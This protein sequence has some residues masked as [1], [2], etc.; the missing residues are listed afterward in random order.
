[1]SRF[2]R[3]WWSRR[4]H[5]FRDVDMFWHVDVVKS[6]NKTCTCCCHGLWYVDQ[7]TSI[8][9]SCFDDFWIMLF[10]VVTSWFRVL[11]ILIILWKTCISWYIV[12]CNR[13]HIVSFF[14]LVLF[15]ILVKGDFAIW[16]PYGWFETMLFFCVFCFVTFCMWC[17]AF[18]VY[19][20]LRY[21][22][23]LWSFWWYW[24]YSVCACLWCCGWWWYTWSYHDHVLGWWY[25]DT[26]IVQNL[27]Y[28]VCHKNR[29][30]ARA[31]NII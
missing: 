5:G 4:F 18:R 8:L 26:F 3:F 22:P 9:V 14:M 30:H 21:L 6:V 15:T 24:W 27:D 2:C 12:F 20:C 7:S 11:A 13:V 31:W 29:Y 1:M 10:G 16:G 17:C 28:K 23:Y 25:Y 19:T